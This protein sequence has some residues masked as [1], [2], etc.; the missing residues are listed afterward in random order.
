MQYNNKGNFLISSYV[1]NLGQV[2]INC[3][4]CLYNYCRL[5]S[6][7]NEQRR[8]KLKIK[9]AMLSVEGKG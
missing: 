9:L 3:K 7:T 2:K 1:G 8:E 4:Y 6:S 5:V